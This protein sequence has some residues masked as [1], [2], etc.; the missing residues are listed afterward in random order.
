M[1]PLVQ[2]LFGFS[3]LVGLLVGLLE[4]DSPSV[5]RPIFGG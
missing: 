2:F 3:W 4:G 1:Q 5:Q